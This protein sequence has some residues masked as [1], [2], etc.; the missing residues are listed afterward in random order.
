MERSLK[1]RETPLRYPWESHASVLGPGTMVSWFGSTLCTVAVT[2]ELAG[3]ASEVVSAHRQVAA[4]LTGPLR[5]LGG[6]AWL[7]C[8]AANARGLHASLASRADAASGAVVIFRRP[9][10]SVAEFIMPRAIEPRLLALWRLPL[11]PRRV[12]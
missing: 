8:T 12:A 2:G 1:D 11:R 7:G 10:T 9:C 5:F 4:R 6:D 3:R